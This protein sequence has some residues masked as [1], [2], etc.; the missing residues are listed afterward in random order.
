MKKIR[1]INYKNLTACVVALVL[2]LSGCSLDEGVYSVFTP[3]NFYKTDR[4][5]LSSLSGVYRNFS[6]LS[7]FGSEYRV[8][9]LCADQ[10]VVRGRSN[11]NW[12]DNNT[13]TLMLHTWDD[14]NPLFNTTWNTLFSTVA[15][16][17]SLIPQINGSTA[18]TV[19]GPVAE[20][21]AL[22]AYAY[23]YLMD[24]FGSV[25]I[26]TDPKVD[27]HNL[28][29]Q[30]TRTEIFNFVIK[31]LTEA[32]VD[33]PRQK[34]AG[35]SYY[36]RF[37]REAAYAL[38]ATVNLNA[39]V[40]TGTAHNDD[41]IH[42]AD[43]VILSNSFTL[44]PNY[45]DNFKYNN[46][47]STENI[48]SAVYTP[49]ATGGPGL[50]IVQKVMPAIGSESTGSEGLFGLPYIPQDGFGNHPA[51]I[52]MY[53]DQDVR[54]SMF[55]KTGVLTDPRTGKVVMVNKVES[56]TNSI[57]SSKP[58]AVPYV[59]IAA[60]DTKNQ[61]MNAGEFWIKWG[62]DP[63]TNGGNASNDFSYLRYAD[64]LLIKAEALA[65]KG[66]FTNALPLVNQVRERS[67]ASD[68][69][70]LV[71]NDILDE[72]GRE[73]AFELT[74]RRDLIRFGK[75]NDAWEFKSASASFRTLFPIPSLARGANANLVQNTG[76]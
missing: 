57:L 28:P 54:K 37:T 31:E 64:V 34:V 53:E 1:S 63:T 6:V 51:V 43:S 21:R 5:V 67:N 19:K 7:S 23:F 14:K 11:G 15:Q 2:T 12:F 8:M 52:A 33:L 72:R 27:P 66:D 26:Y 62:L 32:L 22:R 16:A 73:L 18:V 46:E 29:T 9:E 65:R 39:E 42:Y 59:T 76:Y 20:L 13:Q 41:A 70:S 47:L 61:P 50:A 75:F 44:L 56:N 58:T 71:L 40:Y 74:R 3:N 68:L 17:N 49:N 10:L 55:F 24:L 4:E 60:T 30:N 25:P 69:S 36:G 35:P 38:L 48:F 45:L